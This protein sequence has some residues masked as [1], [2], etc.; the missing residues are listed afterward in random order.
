VTG[1]TLRMSRLRRGLRQQDIADAAACSRARVGQVEQLRKVPR[2]WVD[3]Y[4][5]ALRGIQ[6]TSEV[7]ETAGAN[8][9]P[10]AV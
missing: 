7:G 9:A 2:V 1:R 8:E 5:R 6:P 4:R 10:T 3:R